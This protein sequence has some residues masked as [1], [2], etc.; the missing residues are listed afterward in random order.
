M[1]ELIANLFGEYLL[2][3]TYGS[4]TN[5]K[6]TRVISD[7]YTTI[8]KAKEAMENLLHEKQK[9]GYSCAQHVKDTQCSF[10]H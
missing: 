4:C 2:I 3:R 1:L 10:F 7:T 5:A 8:N 6:P 9:R